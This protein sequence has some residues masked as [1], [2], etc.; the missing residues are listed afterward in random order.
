M[1]QAPMQSNMM[2][3][4]EPTQPTGGQDMSPEEA[5]KL[6]LEALTQLNQVATMYGLDLLQLLNESQGSPKGSPP[7]P[8]QLPPPM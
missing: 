5:K 7:P 8:S 6:I 3:Q 1:M 4:A 2:G